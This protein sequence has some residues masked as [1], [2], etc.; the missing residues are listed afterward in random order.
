MTVYFGGGPLNEWNFD[1]RL[2]RI[3]TRGVG[4]YGLGVFGSGGGVLVSSGPGK[5]ITREH[6][7]IKALINLPGR[8]LRSVSFRHTPA[9]QKLFNYVPLP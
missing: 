7:L 2:M 1:G 3:G 4:L 6:I 5:V 9:I 8:A